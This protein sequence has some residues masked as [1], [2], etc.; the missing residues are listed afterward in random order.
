[1]TLGK[2]N[3]EVLVN[4]YDLYAYPA[5]KITLLCLCNNKKL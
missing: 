2:V 3:C 5:H 1:M 4:M